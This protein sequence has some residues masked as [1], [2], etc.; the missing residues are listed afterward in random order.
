MNVKLGKCARLGHPRAATAALLLAQ[1]LIGVPLPTQAAGNNNVYLHGALVA[2]PCVIPPGDEEITLDFGTIIDKYLYLNTRTLGQAFEIHLEECDLTLG[3]T[4][5]VTFT[6]T[7]SSALPGL[8]AVDGGSEAA[9]IS[10]GFETLA[11]KPLP[12]NKASD[13]SWLQAGSNLIALKAYVQGEPLAIENKNIARGRFSAVATFH[14]E[15]E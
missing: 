14:L 8:L 12:L 6:G 2:E 11:A 15:Y 4:V 5:N 1:M 9:G 13:K 3:K 10:I 7:E